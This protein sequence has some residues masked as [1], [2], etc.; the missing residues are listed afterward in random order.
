MLV[1]FPQINALYDN[2]KLFANFAAR[3]PEPT[4]PETNIDIEEPSSTRSEKQ[5]VLID[6]F[7][8]EYAEVHWIYSPDTLVEYLVIYNDGAF[9]VTML[10]NEDGTPKQYQG[11]GE[12]NEEEIFIEIERAKVSSDVIYIIFYDKG[13]RVKYMFSRS[14]TSADITVLYKADGSLDLYK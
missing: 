3:L 7:C 1:A 6:Y 5:M 12:E 9:A 8:F 10:Y 4:R 11:N 14:G 2:P 13:T